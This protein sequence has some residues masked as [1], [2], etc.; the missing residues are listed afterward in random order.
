[1][2]GREFSEALPPITA[3]PPRCPSLLVDAL[4]SGTLGN[5]WSLKTETEGQVCVR[6]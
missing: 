2:E 5:M 1:M 6:E 4:A 3:T